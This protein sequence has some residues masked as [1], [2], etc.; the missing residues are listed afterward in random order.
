MGNRGGVSRGVSKR[1]NRRQI[2]DIQAERDRQDQLYKVQDH[3]A[4]RW[5]AILV[6]EVGEVAKEIVDQESVGR[7]R[8]ELVQVAATALAWLEAHDRGYGG[9]S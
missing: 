8:M 6:E 9:H 3:S 5:L 4:S 7:L 2:A 1:N